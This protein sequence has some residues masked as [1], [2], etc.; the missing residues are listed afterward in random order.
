MFFALFA[1]NVRTSARIALATAGI[2]GLLALAAAGCA[3]A[4]AQTPAARF[5]RARL[6]S[7]P[8]VASRSWRAYQTDVNPG[9]GMALLTARS[10]VALSGAP[11]NSLDRGLS[12]PAGLALAWP[13]PAL[14]ASRDGGRA[15][16]PSLRP[17]GGLWGIYFAGPLD[18]WA[19]GVRALY[20][21]A[22]GGRRWRR[23]AEPGAGAQQ[24]L[25][26]VAF[27]DRSRGYG[28]ITRGLLVA[29]R[30]GGSSWRTARAPGRADALCVSDG[31]L[32]IAER[33]GSVWRSS[34]GSRWRRVAPSLQRPSEYSG[35]WNELSCAAGNAV[36]LSQSFCEAAC[37]G[38]VESVVRQS[39]DGGRDFRRV[40][41]VESGA[42]DQRAPTPAAA[43]A[44]AR[45]SLCLFE[46]PPAASLT[47]RCTSSGG[48]KWMTARPP[49]LP[50][51]RAGEG[52]VHLTGAGFVGG[53]DGLLA[54]EDSALGTSRS[55][56]YRP[57]AYATRDAGARWR[58]VY[59]G[60]SRRVPP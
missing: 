43:V 6:R 38:G 42:G 29:T 59:E 7:R 19:V 10:A 53:R 9:S 36:E 24:A 35:W 54:L 14:I 28:L 33:D 20:R 52:F 50:H 16:A 39:V 8:S 22:D 13:S 34:A 5:A 44:F 55:P 41:R 4:V 48:A 26:R 18:G 21:T 15:W 31:A 47:I 30:N 17:A 40:G 60:P 32:L 1:K 51:R 45:L 58:R 12:A 56:R 3:A 57:L 27:A 23:A 2:G 25:V 49:A 37:G 46:Y 11:V